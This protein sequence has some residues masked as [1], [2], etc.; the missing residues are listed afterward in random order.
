M[1][2]AGFRASVS[3]SHNF[4]TARIKAA[5]SRGI[6]VVPQETRGGFLL[7]PLPSLHCRLDEQDYETFAIWGIGCLGELAEL[8][9]EELISRLG[10]RAKLWLKLSRGTAE[11]LFQPIEAK[12]ELKEHIEFETHIEQLDSL[13]FIAANMINNLVSRA[14]CRALSLA[15]LSSHGS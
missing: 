11:H 1:L 8:P 6:T 5:F 2:S 3:V 9:E 10:Q 12:F 13:L 15:T 14:T 7:Q 4:D